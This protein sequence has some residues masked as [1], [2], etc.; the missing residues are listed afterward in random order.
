M[1]S[2]WE[3]FFLLILTLPILGH[4]VILPLMIDV[5]GRDAWI[6]IFLSLPFAFLFALSI[7]FIKVKYSDKNI[8]EIFTIILGEKLGKALMFIL[9]I[10]FLFI[11]VISFST[12]VD[13]VYILFL[14]DTP[15]IAIIIWFLIF[16]MYGSSRRMKGIALTAG[17]LAFVALTTGN[18]ITLLDTQLKEWGH[19][20]P[21]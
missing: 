20:E 21:V 2:K 14:P 8:K 12:F 5:A 16:I 3:T 19:L 15:P 17:V 11:T 7:Y 4:V 6:S 18:T 1:L 13:F 10:Y 9:M